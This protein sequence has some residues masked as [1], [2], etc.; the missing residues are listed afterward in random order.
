MS[1]DILSSFLDKLSIG[2]KGIIGVDIGASKIKMAELDKLSGGNF[3]LS[4]YTT[5]AIPEGTILDNEIQNEDEVLKA[6]RLGFKQL[7]SSRKNVCVGISGPSTTLK[8]LQLPEGLS[9]DERHE[10][11]QWDVEQYLPFPLEEGFTSCSVARVNPGTLTDVIVGAAKKDLVNKYKNL[12]EKANVKVRIVDLSAAAILNVFELVLREQINDKGANWLLLEIGAMKTQF[13]ICKGGILTFFKEINIGGNTITEE[14]QREMSVTYAEAESLK[15]QGD[16]K[17]NIPEEI[18]A[19][20]RQVTDTF[21]DEINT[22][23]E[24]WLS[25]SGEHELAGCVITGGGALI[26]GITDLLSEA[27]ATDVI[28][29]NPFNKITYNKNTISESLMNDIAY[30]GVCAIGLAMRSWTP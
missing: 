6:L 12:V 24:F 4:K 16:G 26:P 15:V 17:G 9:E 5:V 27:L 18:L 22:T 11:S 7:K 10:Q 28:P 13:I 20:I 14:I 25:S 19:I 2:D 3:K 21:I 23:Q 30:K 29:L 8:K 1:V